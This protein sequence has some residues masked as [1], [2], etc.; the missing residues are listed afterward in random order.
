MD[1]ELTAPQK[2]WVNEVREFLAEHFGPEAQSEA[3]E[4]GHEWSDRPAIRN[5]RAALARRGWLALTLGPEWGGQGRTPFE[6]LLL[7]DEFAYFGAPSID[8][9]SFAVA[10]TIDRY[11]TEDQK[12]R[13]LPPIV[14]GEAEFALGYSEPD[15]GSDLANL[16]T[17]AERTTGGW[18]VTGEKIWNTGAEYCTTEWLACRTDRDA[19]RHRGISVFIVPLDAAGISIEPL[20]TWGGLRTNR[21]RFDHVHV[22][23]EGLVGTLHGGWQVIAMALDLERVALGLT[24]AVRR[25]VTELLSWLRRDA[26][27]RPLPSS[28]AHRVAELAVDVELARLLNYRAAWLIDSGVVPYAEAS[29]TKI[30]TTELNARAAT[31][32]MEVLGSRGRLAPGDAR[33]ALGGLAQSLARA[34]PYLRFGGGNNEIQRDIVAQQGFGLPRQPR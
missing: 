28:V 18:T 32:A 29:M 13:W 8:L 21:V 27:R 6:Q 2:D 33:V 31:L 19:P 25:L 24:G 34:A 14:S 30:C 26:P 12:K 22:P 15:A 9:S 1:F 3:A 17:F 16:R 23:E 4:Q 11:G 10:P 5:F 7:M 20:F